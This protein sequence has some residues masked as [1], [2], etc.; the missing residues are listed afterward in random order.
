M[1]SSSTS[2]C[3]NEAKDNHSAQKRETSTTPAEKI[4]HQ[5]SRPG[6]QATSTTAKAAHPS[7]EALSTNQSEASTSSQEH[8][9]DS[10]ANINHTRVTPTNQR[11]TSTSSTYETSIHQE[12]STRETRVSNTNHQQPRHRNLQN[13]PSG[14]QV[15]GADI[16]R[17]PSEQG[18]QNSS[19]LSQRHHPDH[20]GGTQPATV[21]DIKLLHFNCQGANNK[22][23]AI[24]HAVR[25]ENYDIVCLQDTRLEPSKENPSR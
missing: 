23:P 4:N 14:M 6:N 15:P 22:K 11:E 13:G 24:E 8:P 1:L 7:T 19:R 16:Q 5:N 17:S 20:R 21:R 9:R 2:S 3:S 25:D 10:P 18:S 12:Q